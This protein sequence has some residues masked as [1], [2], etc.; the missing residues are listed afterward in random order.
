MNVTF[1]EMSVIFKC[2]K[3]N[4]NLSTKRNEALIQAG[5]IPSTELKPSCIFADD[6]L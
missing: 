4:K 3:Y 2:L 1:S 6:L 5:I